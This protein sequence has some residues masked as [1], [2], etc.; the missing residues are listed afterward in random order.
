ML[1]LLGTAIYNGTVAV[2]GLPKQDDLLKTGDPQS[3]PALARSPLMTRNTAPEL[4]EKARSPYAPRAQLD[5]SAPMGRGDP[6]SLK[7][8]LVVKVKK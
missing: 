7:E 4:G 6:A 1:L 2:P 8:S 5:L 3:S